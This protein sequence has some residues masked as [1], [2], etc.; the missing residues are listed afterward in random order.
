MSSSQQKY[1]QNLAGFTFNPTKTFP[2]VSIK[3]QKIV[4]YLKHTSHKDYYNLPYVI[5]DDGTRTYFTCMICHNP[6]T[7]EEMSRHQKYCNSHENLKHNKT[8][9]DISSASQ[10]RLYTCLD[11]MILLSEK[12]KAFNEKKKLWFTFKLAFMTLTLPCEQLHDE[13]YIKKNMLNRFLT[14]MRRKFKMNFYLWRM[15]PQKDGSIHFHII[16]DVYAHYKDI[17]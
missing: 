4:T 14:Q 10:Q 7:A 3:P 6:L 17:Q 13:M 2:M 5:N 8:D 11:W 1:K 15:E 16:H 9:G 12:K